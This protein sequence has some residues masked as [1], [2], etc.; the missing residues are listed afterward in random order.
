MKN[1]E[2]LEL[3]GDVNDDFIQAADSAATR[4][5]FRWRTFVAC[6]ACMALMVCAYP[7]YRMI[8]PPLHSYTIEAGGNASETLD[9]DKAVA[10]G[11][12]SS[13]PGGVYVGDGLNSAGDDTPEDKAAVGQYDRLLQG[14]GVNEGNKADYPGWF[15]GAWVHGDKLTVAIVDGFRN[16]ELESEIL[17]WVQSDITF[18]DAQYSYAYLDSL[19]DKTMV[20]ID[21]IGLNYG[22]GVNVIANC[23]EVELYS[24]TAAPEFNKVLAGLSK[25]DPAGDAIDIKVFTDQVNVLTDNVENTM[26]PTP[27]QGRS[28]APGGVTEPVPGL[29]QNG[30]IQEQGQR[31]SEE[32]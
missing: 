22:I 4:S 1:Y 14:M 32:D 27:D 12:Q 9:G 16:P 20:C 28:I 10:G 17:D 8:H 31:A 24:E 23:L 21:G 15:A 3:I 18:V 26:E 29:V 30:N 19:M 13:L 7:V 6:A 11:G 25:L 2:L 5:R